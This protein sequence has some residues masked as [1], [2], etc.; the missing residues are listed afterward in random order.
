MLPGLTSTSDRRE[1]NLFEKNRLFRQIW[2]K[3]N[4]Q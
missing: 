1:A 2:N 4:K 3:A